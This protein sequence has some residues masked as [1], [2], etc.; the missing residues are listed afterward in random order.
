MRAHMSNFSKLKNLGDDT[1]TKKK[2][3]FSSDSGS[4]DSN[5]SSKSVSPEPEKKKKSGFF[6][7]MRKKVSKKS[8]KSKKDQEKD[9]SDND[10]SLDVEDYASSGKSTPPKKS[11]KPIF[12]KE[13]L[14]LSFEDS[15][16]DSNIKEVDKDLV[17]KQQMAE[18]LKQLRQEEDAIEKGLESKGDYEDENGIIHVVDSDEEQSSDSNDD[19]SEVS[20]VE[21]RESI[22]LDEEV[23]GSGPQVENENE[24]I[25]EN[26]QG[27]KDDEDSVSVESVELVKPDAPGTLFKLFRG[28]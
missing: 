17:K 5:S 2:R 21:E 11:K 24:K 23:V 25:E 4:N 12:D 20:G 6:S 26:E 10:D 1:N 27:Q 14:S 28:S 7:K 16:E 15:G 18:R 13:D 3:K 8:K 19:Y 22:N 9:K